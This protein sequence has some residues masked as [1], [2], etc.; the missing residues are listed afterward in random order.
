[1]FATT[2]LSTSKKT[3]QAFSIIENAIKS[4]FSDKKRDCSSKKLKVSV[5]DG[6][7]MNKKK[8]KFRKNLDTY[9]TASSEDCGKAASQICLDIEYNIS[10][11][12]S[13]LGNQVFEVESPILAKRASSRGPVYD[14]HGNKKRIR[15][16]PDQ[17]E[18]EKNHTCPYLGCE[19]SYTSKC[20]LY[21][22]IKRTHREN[23]ILK[24]GETAPI[25]INS[26]VK[27]GVDIYK[28]FKKAKAL[29]YECRP[30]FL[31]NDGCVSNEKSE[32]KTPSIESTNERT[33]KRGHID[34][35]A[36]NSSIKRK[37]SA[38]ILT[39]CETQIK[40]VSNNE[41]VVGRLGMEVF[42]EDAQ[43][44]IFSWESDD[45]RK[46]SLTS[47][48]IED[49]I[50]KFDN[51]ANLMCGID[52]A[53]M[54]PEQLSHSREDNFDCYSNKGSI[55]LGANELSDEELCGLGHVKMSDE[56]KGGYDFFDLC[57]ENSFDTNSLYAF[58][59]ELTGIQPSKAMKI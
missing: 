50:T 57:V 14:E 21:L 32:I 3:D 41:F 19:K 12:I 29:E 4:V 36:N 43:H 44:Q 55:S 20:S 18:G 49:P 33:P 48:N 5:G 28:V 22:H 24:E 47:L 23:E 6:E 11:C 1:M 37:M 35:D 27:K 10:T 51:Q 54:E 16:R 58:E 8:L 7:S 45:S 39:Q 26:K 9:S 30:E 46:T 15:R 52:F 2:Y 42:Q 25:R 56:L 53:N 34:I 59:M 17:L 31:E 13:H 40:C 38:D